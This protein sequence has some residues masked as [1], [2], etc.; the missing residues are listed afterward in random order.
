MGLLYIIQLAWILLDDSFN[1]VREES[2]YI[3]R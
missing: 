1:V 2:Y 3:Q